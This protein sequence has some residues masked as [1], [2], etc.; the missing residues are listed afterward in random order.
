MRNGSWNLVYDGLDPDQEG[1]REALCTLGN[2]VF[3]TRG[4]AE[5]SHADD[6]HYPGTYVTGAYDRLPSAVGDKRIV[7][8]DLVN[9][10]NWL[11]MSY[12]IEDGEWLG[13]DELS[14]REYRQTLDL[15]HGLLTRTF[16][17]VDGRGR[18]TSVTFTRFVHMESYRLAGV[19]MELT[20]LNWEG[21]LTLRAGLEGNV[22]N[23]G[24]E[25]YRALR[26]DHLE[27]IGKGGTPEGELWLHVRTKQSRFEVAMAARFSLSVQ[28][29]DRDA[30]PSVAASEMGVDATW[31]VEARSQVPVRLDKTVAVRTSRDRA[32]A[33]VVSDAI[34]DARHASPFSELLK[35]QRIAWEGLWERFDVEMD[36]SPEVELPEHSMQLIVRLHIFHLIQ[37]ASTHTLAMDASVPARG[38]HGEAYRGHIF[39]DEMYILP[40]Y[41]LRDPR[42]ART[43][44]LYRYSRLSEARRSAREAGYAGAMFPWQSGSNGREESQVIHLN[45][46]SGKW[47]PDRSHLQR[48]VNAAIAYNIWQYVHTTGD[49][50]FLRTYGAEVL[51]EIAR[52]WASAAVWNPDR[53]AYEIDKVMG[54]DE[55]HEAYP[56]ASKS[57]QGGLRNNAYTN[58]MASWC[59]RRADEAVGLLDERTR[60]QLLDRLSLS[61]DEMAQWMEIA[62]KLRIPVMENG[63]IEQFDGYGDL[64]EIDWDVY[65]KKYGNI[66]RMDRILKAEGDSP[67]R[68][69]V[70]KQ[71]DTCM[72]FYLLEF[73]ELKALLGEMGY[74]LTE[75]K[76]RQT[77]AYYRA[78]TSHG[79]T[80]SHL[81]YAAILHGI[82]PSESWDHFVKALQ[83]DI[84][85]IQGGT[86]PEG[87]HAAVMAGTVR[88]IVER[89][90]G[91]KTDHER[92]TITPALPLGVLRVA[93][94]V[95]QRG[96]VVRIAVRE[97]SVEVCVL[98]GS[99]HAVEVSVGEETREV[100]PG[101]TKR[102]GS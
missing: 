5:E 34:R 75:E 36:V 81:V 41:L 15:R 16:V 65:R 61:M 76:A 24:V 48:H 96:S 78:R 39:W 86:T 30:A 43:L 69:K 13:S 54:P 64:E 50:Q 83:S 35:R 90:A 37:T 102:F 18:E 17:V 67:D 14:M 68:Y 25:R 85:D 51:L 79:S 8:E 42:I 55:F 21:R 52:F 66:G 19:R 59:I 20:P 12:R 95:I 56:S 93:F 80:L 27:V 40:F 28:G 89:F 57:D 4:A 22:T 60:D 2:G 47:D 53:E 72:L 63:I 94:Y 74:S 62:T 99:P 92:I 73:D 71:A 32:L 23:W 45:P 31:G 11:P 46:R 38:L 29:R 44:L 87:I 10:P 7:N 6:I 88:H 91:V 82:K 1:L 3:A 101:E 97:K 33:D 49:Y 98:D 70:A 26:G 9:L 77:I 84:Q 58:V 100:M